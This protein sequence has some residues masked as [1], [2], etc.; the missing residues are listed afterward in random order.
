[1]LGVP[2][3]VVVDVASLKADDCIVHDDVVFDRWE[4]GLH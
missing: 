2:G 4:L 3:V 1:M